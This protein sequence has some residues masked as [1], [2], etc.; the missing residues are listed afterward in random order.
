LAA[1][2]T[3]QTLIQLCNCKGN[4]E[5]INGSAFRIK[6]PRNRNS[7]S[8]LLLWRKEQGYWKIVSQ[9]LDPGLA[10]E[11]SVPDSSLRSSKPQAAPTDTNGDR[12]IIRTTQRFFNALFLNRDHE[13]AFR[14]FG[15]SAACRTV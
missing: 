10:E 13:A 3:V 6:A 8:L 9:Q 12:A 7:G 1:E 5:P 14:F 2:L 4:M 11:D 15:R